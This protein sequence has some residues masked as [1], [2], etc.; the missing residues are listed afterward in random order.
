MRELNSL[1]SRERPMA[2]SCEHGNETP[3]S[4]IGGGFLN[5]LSNYKHLR[6]SSDQ[7]D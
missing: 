6:Y 2:G 5:K 1:N 3:G 4:V 7:W